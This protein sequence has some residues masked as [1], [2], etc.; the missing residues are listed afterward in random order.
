MYDLLILAEGATGVDK[1]V[2]TALFFGLWSVGCLLVGFL[3][4]LFGLKRLEKLIK[5]DLDRD[6]K[7]GD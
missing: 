6:G 5:T 1:F 4:C 7:I 3:A 2:D